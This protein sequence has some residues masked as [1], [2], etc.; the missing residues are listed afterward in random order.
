MQPIVSPSFAAW[1]QSRGITP[2]VV[3][4]G[5]RLI[6]EA[7]GRFI[8]QVKHFMEVMAE[9]ARQA[10]A[11]LA[12]FVADFTAAVRPRPAPAPRMLPPLKL[13]PASGFGPPPVPPVRRWR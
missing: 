3:V 13:V 7:F 10:L 6:R 9:V 1:Q 12:D 4:H 8:E 5:A 2:W 11:V